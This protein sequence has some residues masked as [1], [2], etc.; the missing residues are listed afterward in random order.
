[1]NKVM[2]GGELLYCLDDGEWRTYTNT[3]AI[4][5]ST[6]IIKAKVRYLDRESNTTWMWLQ[7]EHAVDAN[8][9]EKNTGATF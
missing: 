3:I 8:A 1:M 7:E 6:Q 9:Q 2:E 5:A 4:P